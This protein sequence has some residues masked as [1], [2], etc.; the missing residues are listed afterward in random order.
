M[1][2]TGLRVE[3]LCSLTLNDLEISPRKGKVVVQS[4]KGPKYREVPLN[5][6]T[7]KALEAY[8]EE[9]PQVDDEHVFIG[10]RGNGLTPSAVQ[11]IVQKYAYHAGLESVT[12]HVLRHT[13]WRSLIDRGVDLVT[14]K[15]LMG[16]TRI[17]STARYTRLS[18]KDLEGALA[19]L[20]LEEL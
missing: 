19:R 20:E 5:L 6:D 8:F 13:F 17:D 16:H 3:E 18:E 9:E 14:V 4:G 7:R 15:E 10:Q 12:P 1:R 11:A 2:H